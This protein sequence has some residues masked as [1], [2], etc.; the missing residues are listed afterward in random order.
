M[1]NGTGADREVP[2]GV[3]SRMDDA[4]GWIAPPRN[5]EMIASDLAEIETHL[6]SEGHDPADFDRVALQ[7]IHMV[8]GADDSQAEREQRRI[9][10]YI[11]AEGRP[12]DKRMTHS[13]TGSVETMRETVAE[14]HDLGFDELIL[15]PMS[16]EPGELDRQLRLIDDLLHGQYP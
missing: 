11:T 4:D 15:H 7:Y 13:L 8:P 10:D 14:Y 5:T 9:F 12:V 3:L 1:G 2:D 6:K 16:T